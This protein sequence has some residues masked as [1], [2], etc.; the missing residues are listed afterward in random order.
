MIDRRIDP[1]IILQGRSPNIGQ[2][3]NGMQNRSSARQRDQQNAELFPLQLQQQQQAVDMNQANI[4]TNAQNQNLMSIASTIPEL[5]QFIS[6]GDSLGAL[7]YLERRKQS[8][9][10]QGRN[11]QETLEAIQTVTNGNLDQLGQELDI[12][13]NEVM[14][15]GLNGQPTTSVGQ[16]ER[17]SLINAYNNDPSSPEGQSAGVA[18]GITPRASTSSTERIA[19]SQT[20]TDRVANSGGKIAA[21]KA[22]S[23]NIAK[24]NQGYIDTGID[25]ADSVANLTKTLNLLKTV[26][27]GG[28]NNAAL[29]ASRLLGVTGADEAE[30]S[31]NMGKAILA[32]LKPIFGAAFTAQEGERLE[33]LEASFGKSTQANVRL[34]SNVLKTTERAARRGLAAAKAEGDVFT[35]NEIQTILDGIGSEAADTDFT[36]LEQKPRFVIESID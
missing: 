21:Q 17:A 30:L 36:D 13:E 20:V 5:R 16:R 28:F 4:D 3:L 15:R 6:S 8:L 14:N 22:T 24:R 2:M 11:P 23:T 27:T 33:K 35:A 1:R 34:I 18:L 25:A 19:N 29:A 7:S 10:A 12:V 32:Q 9:I 26:D 31:A